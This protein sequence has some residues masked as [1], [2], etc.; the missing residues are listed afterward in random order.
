MTCSGGCKRCARSGGTS[1]ARSPTTHGRMLCERGHR[2]GGSLTTVE[3]GRKDERTGIARDAQCR[4]PRRSRRAFELFTA[5][6]NQWWRRG[7]YYWNDRDRARGLRFEPHVGGRFIEV[8]D[9]ATGEG[10]EIG[11]ITVWEPGRRLAYTW[12]ESDWGPEE[13]TQVD[14]RFEPVATGTR[15]TV[16]H[17]GWERVKN[18]AE[19][20]R[21]YATGHAQLLGWYGEAAVAA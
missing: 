15:V 3:G 9:E 12:R 18:G 20:S 13:Q 8:Y 7:T 4:G 1:S 19:I 5:G 14:V 11:R 16:V 17:S 21:G 2:V 6:I 10:F